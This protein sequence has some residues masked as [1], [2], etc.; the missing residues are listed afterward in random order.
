MVDSLSSFWSK[1]PYLVHTVNSSCVG[2]ICMDLYVAQEIA[3]DVQLLVI[4]QS[5]NFCHNSMHVYMQNETSH[6][7]FMFY[8]LVSV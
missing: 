6:L 3:F 1:Y 4:R 8:E 7:D 2:N 5:L